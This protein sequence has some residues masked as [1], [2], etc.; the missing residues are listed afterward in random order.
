M[1]AGTHAA[2]Y[3]PPKEG[4]PFLVVIIVD[5]RVLACEPVA[6]LAEGQAI[7]EQTVRELPRIIEQAE[8][9]QEDEK[10]DG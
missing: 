9:E 10:D 3:H 4:C 1:D 5:G 2:V 8:R 6:S 7:L